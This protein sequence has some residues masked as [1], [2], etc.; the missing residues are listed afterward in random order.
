L[1]AMRVHEGERGGAKTSFLITII[2]LGI[3][4][5]C[6]VKVAPA[7]FANYQLNDS[8]TSEARFANSTY[9]KKTPDDIQDD[10]YRKAVELGVPIKKQDVKVSVDGNL[11][12][13][14]VDYSVTWDLIVTQIVHQFHD[15]ADSHSI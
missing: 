2:I 10:V 4:V 13:V 5:F 3:M 6:A 14:T 12:T 8:M 9:P 11:I 1:Q 7:F 15:S